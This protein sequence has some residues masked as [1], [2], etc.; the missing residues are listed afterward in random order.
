MIPDEKYKSLL[1]SG[2][3]LDHYFLLCNIKNNI[4]PVDSK[5]IQG[6]INLLTKKGYLQDDK[7]TE[8]GLELIDT[9]KTSA[10]EK[11]DFAEWVI[12]VHK[13]LQDR[14]VE[15]T[16]KKQVM[17]RFKGTSRDYSFLYGVRDLSLK[18]QRV[19]SLYKLKDYEKIERTLI[20]HVERCHESNHWFPLVHYYILKDN[21]SALVTDMEN[22]E[23][24]EVPLNEKLVDPKKLF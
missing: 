23:V 14:L 12:N 4:K 7:L 2:L 18:L 9:C 15:L 21:V 16:G 17:A 24:V 20:R 13:K 1:E 10:G 6:F 22:E 3:I 8:K 19:I 5:R 11:F